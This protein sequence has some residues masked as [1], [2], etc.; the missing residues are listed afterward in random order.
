MQQNSRMAQITLLLLAALTPMSTVIIASALPILDDFFQLAPQSV[1]WVIS[2]F[3]FGIVMGMIFYAPLANRFGRVN[4]L[5]IGLLISLIGL[6]LCVISFFTQHFPTLLAGR[7]ITAIGSCAANVCVTLLIVELYPLNKARQMAAYITLSA[8]IAGS[9]GITIGSYLTVYFHWVSCF[10]LMIGLTCFIYVMLRSLPETLTTSDRQSIQV[11]KLLK[12]YVNV[13]KEPLTRTAITVMGAYCVFNY[14]YS[15]VT[16]ILAIDNLKLSIEAYGTW[17]IM[18]F[19]GIIL[20]SLLSA[21]LANRMEVIQ[22][23]KRALIL[24]IVCSVLLLFYRIVSLN[25]PFFFFLLTSLLFFSSMLFYPNMSTYAV[26][27]SKDRASASSMT[28]VVSFSIGLISLVILGIL[29]IE[30]FYQFTVIVVV[31]HVIGY[32]LLCFYKPSA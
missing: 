8:T 29:P 9:L 27:K 5:K 31:V 16:P 30:L 23:I 4:T 3:I 22:L 6:L 14:L 13:L 7:W 10:F 18:N 15:G 11:A 12:G 24:G 32:L 17:H 21:Y 26:S 1:T 20:G 25:Q 28:K 19:V 2:L